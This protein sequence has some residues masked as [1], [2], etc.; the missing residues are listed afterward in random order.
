MKGYA[1]IRNSLF[2]H[3]YEQEETGMTEADLITYIALQ[4]GMEN[5]SLNTVKHISE[6][7]GYGEAQISQSLKKLEKF[8]CVSNAYY[9]GNIVN[10]YPDGKSKVKWIIEKKKTSKNETYWVPNFL[11][12]F[13]VHSEVMEPVS[14][15]YFVVT[16][17]DFNLLKNNH[18]T[19]SEFI[20]YLILLKGHKY[21]KPLSS[22]LYFKK[23]TIAKKLR[24]VS[25]LTVSKHMNK[26]KNFT[27]DG[28]EVPLIEEDRHWNYDVRVEAGEEASSK[29]KPIYNIEN[30][31]NRK[32][33]FE[34]QKKENIMKTDDTRI[35]YESYLNKTDVI[36]KYFR[37]EWGKY[38]SA[39][40]VADFLGVSHPH[41]TTTIKRNFKEFKKDGVRKLTGWDLNNFKKEHELNGVKSCYLITKRA[42][43]RLCMIFKRSNSATLMK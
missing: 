31:N 18:L 27:L 2:D 21:D 13:K 43:I 12:P 41:L 36:D 5:S 3:Y 26:F 40:S 38:T 34:K 16:E 6:Y 23:S 33:V 37:M 19:R 25:G 8:K 42:I 15:S 7:T 32:R 24:R 4:M 29:I 10:L 35:D 22:Q 39:K 11:P 1:Y 30:Y 20:T 28:K 9:D 14:T 17:E